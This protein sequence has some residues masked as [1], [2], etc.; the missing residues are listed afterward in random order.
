MN[1]L[2]LAL[3][4]GCIPAVSIAE[5]KNVVLVNLQET[6]CYDVIILCL[7][8]HQTLPLLCAVE[9]SDEQ[10]NTVLEL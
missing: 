2:T 4:H 6:L 8:T 5:G 3:I 1:N 7:V 9:E 10:T